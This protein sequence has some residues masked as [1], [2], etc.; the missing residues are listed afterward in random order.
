MESA[1]R[2]QETLA[3]II[4]SKPLLNSGTKIAFVQKKLRKLMP[5][6]MKW[7]WH[8]SRRRRSLRRVTAV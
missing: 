4:W 6:H 8:R 2:T 3:A 1:R 5:A 7:H